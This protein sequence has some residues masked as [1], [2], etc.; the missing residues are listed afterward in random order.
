MKENK[1]NIEEIKFLIP[2]YISGALSEKEALLVKEAI[3][4]YPE[5]NE[6]YIDMKA[7]FEFA[8]KVEIEEPS[9][10]YFNNLLPRIHQ[11][12]GEREEKHT[13]KNPLALIWKILVPAAAVIIL[14]IIYMIANNPGENIND[15]NK[16]IGKT[17]SVKKEIE[18]KQTL[19]DVKEKKIEESTADKTNI[20]KEQKRVIRKNN[21][22]KEEIEQEEKIDNE[23]EEKIQVP[24]VE[25]DDVADVVEDEPLI[26]GAGERGTFDADIESEIDELTK[27][28]EDVILKQLEKSNL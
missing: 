9:P 22:V 18:Q 12:I 19:P 20:N 3:D 5:V 21:N 23:I 16:T 1:L 27:N 14:F 28:E 8:D 11:K 17:D 15:K 25:N 24:A 26:L 10:Q 7:A 4:K 2:D 6:L 13:A